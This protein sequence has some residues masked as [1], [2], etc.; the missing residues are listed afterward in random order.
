MKSIFIYSFFNCYSLLLQSFISPG[1]SSPRLPTPVKTSQKRDD[2]HAMP[3]VSRVIGSAL[4]QISGSTTVSILLPMTEC[5]V[6]WTS[7]VDTL[8]QRQNLRWHLLP[9]GMF[10][11]HHLP[12]NIANRKTLVCTCQERNYCSWKLKIKV[13]NPCDFSIS[14][15]QNIRKLIKDGLI[16]RKPVAV[17]SRA[18]VRQNAIAR[19]K[20]RHT[21]TGKRKGTANARMPQKVE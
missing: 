9:G 5:P 4:A 10:A 19:R 12:L 1:I 18:R 14:T 7:S 13:Y 3:Q 2:C 20:G 16:I 17:H 15:G 21:G 11:N 8:L 6:N